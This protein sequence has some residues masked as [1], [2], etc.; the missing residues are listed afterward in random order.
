MGFRYFFAGMTYAD[1]PSS[2]LANPVYPPPLI[3]HTLIGATDIG[4]FVIAAVLATKG[5]LDVRGGVRISLGTG[6]ALLP[7]Q[8][9]AGGGITMRC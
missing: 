6:L 5:N 7:A 1:P 4:A 9:A 2:A 8:A 3:I